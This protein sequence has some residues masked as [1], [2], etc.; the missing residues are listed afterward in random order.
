MY[1]LL[2]TGFCGSSLISAIVNS[3]NCKSNSK[4][5]SNSILFIHNIFKILSKQEEYDGNNSYI[6]DLLG[7]NNENTNSKRRESK[8]WFNIIKC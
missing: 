8:K 3:L 6:S 7:N 5:I 4:D 2:K 1:I